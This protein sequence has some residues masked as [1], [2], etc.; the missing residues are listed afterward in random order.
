MHKKKRLSEKPDLTVA[1][2]LIIVMLVLILT[3]LFHATPPAPVSASVSQSIF[4]SAR[5]MLT[6]RQIAQKPHPTGTFEN[7]KVR[8]YLVAE[9]KG[10]GLESHIQNALGINK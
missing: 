2:G 4:S 7:E 10:L 9:L 5:A 3:G 8:N 6:V 1:I